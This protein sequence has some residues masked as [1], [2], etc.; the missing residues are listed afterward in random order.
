M[1]FSLRFEPFSLL[2]WM[3]ARFI[4]QRSFQLPFLR[5]VAERVRAAFAAEVRFW[6]LFSLF[7]NSRSSRQVWHNSFTSAFAAEVR[8]WSLFC[9]FSN[10]RSSRQVWHNSFT[11]NSKSKVFKAFA[12]YQEWVKNQ[13]V[14]QAKGVVAQ[15]RDKCFLTEGV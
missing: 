4:W 9:L 5:K 12:K 6:S 2:L 15:G 8:F 13:S 1:E 3:I 7:S 11:F 10:S 14:G